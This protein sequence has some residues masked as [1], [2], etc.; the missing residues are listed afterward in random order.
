[1]HVSGYIS[2]SLHNM[3][4]I[5]LSWI[6]VLLDNIVINL[7]RFYCKNKKFY[8]MIINIKIIKENK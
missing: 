8:F 3:Y 6:Y 5:I 4:V 2:E 7:I 1:M